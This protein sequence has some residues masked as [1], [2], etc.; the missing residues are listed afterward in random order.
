MPIIPI[1]CSMRRGANIRFR[2][3]TKWKN[4][5][6]KPIKD[7]FQVPILIN[8]FNRL[9]YLEQLIAW[10]ERAGYRKIYIIDNNS[11]YPPLVEYYRQSPHTVFRLNRNQGHFSIWETIIFSRFSRDY[12]VYTDPDI[13]PDETCPSDIM[14]YFK[15]LLEA[16]PWAKKVGFGLRIDDLPDHYALKQQVIQWETQFWQR[17]VQQDVFDALIDTTFALYRPGAKGGADGPAI[18]TAGKYIARHMPWYENSQALD[19][20]T[21][22]YL[23]S[24]SKASSWYSATKGENDQY[25][26]ESN[27]Q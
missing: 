25:S 22:Y 24:C 26:H 1:E 20:E 16:Y 7:P 6:A 9:A 23:R 18:R 5:W 17:P 12:Y 2:L 27:G 15:S 19:D 3:W 13:V 11:D 14:S 8:N 21:L 4:Y 10:L